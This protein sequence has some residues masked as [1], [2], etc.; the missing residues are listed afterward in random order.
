MNDKII[1]KLKELK[2]R[3]RTLSTTKFSQGKAPEA[4]LAK[5]AY[6]SALNRLKVH[7]T[8]HDERTLLEL[9]KLT[10]SNTCLPI[11]G[12]KSTCETKLSATDIFVLAGIFDGTQIDSSFSAAPPILDNE[13]DLK[14]LEFSTAY[15]ALVSTKA[16]ILNNLIS[17][18]KQN[19]TILDSKIEKLKFTSILE[20]L[21]GTNRFNSDEVEIELPYSEHTSTCDLVTT[22]HSHLFTGQFNQFGKDCHDFYEAGHKISLN[23]AKKARDEESPELKAHYL[24]LAFNTQL[25][26]THYLAR[27]YDPAHMR[28]Q[29]RQLMNFLHSELSPESNNEAGKTPDTQELVAASLS[30]QMYHEEDEHGLD[31][32][33][34]ALNKLHLNRSNNPSVNVSTEEQELANNIIELAF[35]DAFTSLI[36]VYHGKDVQKASIEYRKY[37]MYPDDENYPPMA[38]IEADKL[39]LR[40]QQLQ[41]KEFKPKMLLRYFDVFTRTDA[42]DAPFDEQSARHFFKQK[43]K[44]QK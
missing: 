43:F 31:V 37:L 17:F 41:L 16:E 33:D 11:I 26:A 5:K 14:S 13:G 20:K 25:F 1:L 34:M 19:N 8:E 27:L 29:K 40:G 9:N 3:Q 39:K 6:N 24:F 30:W 18:L 21:Y 23:Y 12:S 4:K 2:P 15:N 10:Q 42:G 38:C 32:L 7:L 36:E 35:Q 44:P 28:T 22:L